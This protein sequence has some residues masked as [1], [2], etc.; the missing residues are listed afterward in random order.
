MWVVKRWT[1]G[2]PRLLPPLLRSSGTQ[3]TAVFPEHK[4]KTPKTKQTQ[5]KPN[6]QK[7]PLFSNINKVGLEGN[8]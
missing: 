2:R 7:I 8:I 6:K 1:P 4:T 5:N 3:M